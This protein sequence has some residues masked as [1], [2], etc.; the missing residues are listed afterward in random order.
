MRNKILKI[1]EKVTSSQIEL[2]DLY[3]ALDEAI[4]ETEQMIQNGPWTD[5]LIK[6]AS[7][8]GSKKQQR[9]VT[10]TTTAVSTLD[11]SSNY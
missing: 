11:S 8:G 2:R 9:Q 5:F 3:T 7:S 10:A 1:Y 4:H 6:R